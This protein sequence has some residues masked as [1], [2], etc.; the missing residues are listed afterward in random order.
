MRLLEGIENAA[1]VR[2][3]GGGVSVCYLR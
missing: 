1:P 3:S 2:I